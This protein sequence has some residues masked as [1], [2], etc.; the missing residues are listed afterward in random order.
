MSFPKERYRS[1]STTVE[2]RLRVMSLTANEKTFCE[3]VRNA[4]D[5]LLY[6]HSFWRAPTLCQLKFCDLP[7]RSENSAH[8]PILPSA[9]EYLGGQVCVLPLG[10][11]PLWEILDPLLF[12]LCQRKFVF[13]W[14]SSDFGLALRESAVRPVLLMKLGT[15][16]PKNRKYI[17]SRNQNR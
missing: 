15:K 1:L 10:L 2:E 9:V 7:L 5:H 14:T 6:A 12:T 17:Y 4:L 16:L 3:K 11:T 8:C 13:Q